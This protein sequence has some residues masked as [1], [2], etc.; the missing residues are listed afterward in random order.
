MPMGF[1]DYQLSLIRS[2]AQ[3]LPPAWRSRFV[4]VV[5]DQLISE[6]G[7]EAPIRDDLVRAAVSHALQALQLRAA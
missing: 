3:S 5:V 4:E 6:V 2:A 7:A 1:S